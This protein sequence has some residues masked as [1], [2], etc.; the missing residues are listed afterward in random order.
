[1]ISGDARIADD[2]GSDLPDV[3]AARAEALIAGRQMWA[4]AIVA[5][6]DLAD[7]C[8]EITDGAGRVLLMLSLD[9]ALPLRLRD[10]VRP[11]ET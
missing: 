6:R 3:D 9:D 11:R 2:E 5:G 7:R 8:F 10:A 4:A 1:M